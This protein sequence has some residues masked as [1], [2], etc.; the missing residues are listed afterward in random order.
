MGITEDIGYVTWRVEFPQDIQDDLCTAENPDGK[1]TMNDLELA[2]VV[3][4]WLVLEKLVPNLRFK[5]IGMNCDNSTAV[6][7]SNKYRTAKSI[8]AARLLRLLSLR[9][10][11]RQVSPLLVIHISGELNGMADKLSR[12]FGSTGNA[13]DIDESLTNF[14]NKSYPL[15]QGHSWKEFQIPSSLFSRVMSCVRG[16]HLKMGQLLRLKGIDK[17]IGPIGKSTYNSGN[18]APFWTM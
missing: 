7:W 12:S 16:E 6:S 5:H 17:S 8:P 11:R 18:S 13:F 4:G 3:L 14:F 10:H 15:P 9:M 2:G 1:I